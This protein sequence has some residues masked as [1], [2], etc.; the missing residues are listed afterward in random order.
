VHESITKIINLDIN[1]Y[2]AS[3]YY[4]IYMIK[5]VFFGCR[6]IQL[7][8]RQEKELKQLYEEPLLIK[9]SFSRKFPRKVL[10]MRKIALGIGIMSLRTIIDTLKLKLFIGNK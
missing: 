2:Q 5:S 9:I 4:H 7:K 10:Y 6:V 1:L 3:V 8:L